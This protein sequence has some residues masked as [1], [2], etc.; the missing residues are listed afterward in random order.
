[1]VVSGGGDDDDTTN[2]R[3]GGVCREDAR[4]NEGTTTPVSSTTDIRRS[5][6]PTTATYHAP[7]FFGATIYRRLGGKAVE[8]SD[9]VYS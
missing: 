3:I 4:M 8:Q 1:M 9:N 6:T 2:Y 5:R 7:S